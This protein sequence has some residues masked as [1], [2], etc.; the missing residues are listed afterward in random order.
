MKGKT[1]LIIGILLI[2]AVGVM[3]ALPNA[4][5][6]HD[7]SAQGQGTDDP[8]ASKPNEQED[9]MELTKD[10]VIA[11]SDLTEA[12][13]EGIDFEDFVQYF[14]LTPERL[15]QYEP[16]MLLALYRE[17]HG[18]DVNIV[19]VVGMMISKN[20]NVNKWLNA[21]FTELGGESAGLY[22]I[23]VET[24]TNGMYSHPDASSHAAVSQALSQ[25]IRD[26]GLLQVSARIPK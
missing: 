17:A 19:W 5:A 21:V 4:G 2:C 7:S 12:D 10:Y 20:A 3:I 23:L 18:E 15:A 14:Q 24:N 1:L 6:P 8:N 22:R 25:Y 9:A 26:K 13:F 16:A 11:H